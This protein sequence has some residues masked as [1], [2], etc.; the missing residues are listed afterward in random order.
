MHLTRFQNVIFISVVVEM[1]SGYFLQRTV[2]S[3]GF[4]G[5]EYMKTTAVRDQAPKKLLSATSLCRC[6]LP[7]F[8]Q[9]L[10]FQQ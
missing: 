9:A 7:H 8:C 5:T 10:Q 4:K 2:G 6:D 1:I 3:A